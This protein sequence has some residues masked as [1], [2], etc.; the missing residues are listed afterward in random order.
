MRRP[1]RSTAARNGGLALAALIGLLGL[2]AVW[3]PALPESVALQPRA[4]WAPL[5]LGPDRPL[6]QT[7]VSPRDGLVA[8]EALLAHYRSKEPLPSDL[9]ICG[10]LHAVA[11]D[12]AATPVVCWP[13]ADLA[14][15]ARLRLSFPEL[16]RSRDVAY[17]ATF[18]SSAP[19][20]ITLW[21][22]AEEAYADGELAVAGTASAGD[23]SI[24]LGYRY[25]VTDA[26]AD[27]WRLLGRWW[28]PLLCLGLLIGAPG[29]ALATWLGGRDAPCLAL[30]LALAIWP[31]VLLWLTTFGVP[32]GAP[33]IWGL[34]ALALAAG[35]Y[36]LFRRPQARRRWLAT[37]R[38]PAP[39][40]LGVVTALS[41]A[42]RL[43]NVRDLVLPNWVDSLHHT[44][45]AQLIV[46]GQRLP[47]DGG[48]FVAL[49]GFYYHFGFHA[50]AA[51][52]AQTA[53]IASHEAVLIVGQTLLALA[54]LAVYGLAR[55]L[56]VCRTGALLGALVV[57]CWSYMPAYYASWGRYPQMAGLLLVAGVLAGTW[58]LTAARAPT[59]R[60]VLSAG[61]MVAALLLTHYRMLALLVP[62]GL[63]LLLRL[64]VHRRWSRLGRA[65]V[66]MAASLIA[67]G[68]WLGR[69]L[70]PFVAQFAAYYG[71]LTVAPAADD[72]WPLGL[73]TYRWTAYLLG[74]AIVGLLW[75][76][77]GRCWGVAAL[78]L[79]AGLTVLVPNLHWIGLPDL[80]LV[81][82]TTVA[83]A[84]WLPMG[85]LVGWLL[86]DLARWARHR[87]HPHA[88]GALAVA[89]SG[90]LI[91]LALWGTWL[92]VD[93]VNSAT[94]LATNDDLEAAA[95]A[96]DHLPEDAVVL[97]NSAH[98]TNT[99]RRGSDAG[100]WL[101]FLSDREVTLPNALYIQGGP[102]LFAEVNEL[103][104]AVEQTDDL[105]SPELL[106][107][108]Q[109]RGVTHVYVGAAGGPLAPSRLE[110]CPAYAQIYVNGPTRFYAFSSGAVTSR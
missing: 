22:T 100:W 85:V 30:P 17:R 89:G 104:I 94:V 68:P 60:Q 73:L 105:C 42:A 46:E 57:G 36:E 88:R 25:R 102:T 93:T 62:W 5:P 37:L 28:R 9:S 45:I 10:Q 24:S 74:A 92:H 71:T 84:Y 40:L 1:S 21:A 32:Y 23:L 58:R 43:L 65:A 49:P 106:S 47:A 35:L 77:R 98:W 41:L 16:R 44:M 95:W 27:L 3:N 80:W 64:A 91:G 39:W 110:G 66:A 76:L 14:H 13:V 7:F 108:L 67:A 97:V 31:L 78:G 83:I 12:A 4:T 82:N 86:G 15:N 19:A 87:A 48:R 96:R 75:A 33:A 69:L 11:T 61:L 103:A 90:A 59:W 20:A 51:A 81:N 6:A 2:A 109:A 101:P 26:M 18:W 8:V 50:L 34:V 29:L 38:A 63:V 53:A 79:W 99:A 72:A 70:G 52:V 107:R 56:R 54:P 55:G